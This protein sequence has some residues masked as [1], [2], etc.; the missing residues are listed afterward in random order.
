MEGESNRDTNNTVMAAESITVKLLLQC[1]EIPAQIF[2][3]ETTE[4]P[5]CCGLRCLDPNIWIDVQRLGGPLVNSNAGA[6][7]VPQKSLVSFAG[8]SP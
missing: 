6:V 8:L 3:S 4:P 5:F 7:P 2:G 1:G